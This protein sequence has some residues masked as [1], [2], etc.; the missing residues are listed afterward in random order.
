MLTLTLSIPAAP[1]FRFTALKA[2]CI[3][4][5]SILPVNECTFRFFGMVCLSH[6]AITKFGQPTHLRMCL[7]DASVF[8]A[9]ARASRFG[10]FSRHG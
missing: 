8:P 2:W 10:G 6:V 3:N 5:R 4:R 7:S 9:R 1:R